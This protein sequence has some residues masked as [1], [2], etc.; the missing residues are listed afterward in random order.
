MEFLTNLVN[1]L[2]IAIFYFELS[3]LHLMLIII[4]ILVIF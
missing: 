1:F 3:S 2:I 4:L